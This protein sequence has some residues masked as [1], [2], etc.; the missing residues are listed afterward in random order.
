MDMYKLQLVTST[1]SQ[2]GPE[3]HPVFQTIVDA[4]PFISYSGTQVH[5]FVELCLELGFLCCM[6]LRLY[7]HFVSVF[8]DIIQNTC[9]R[10]VIG[11][12]YQMDP[13]NTR[14][15]NK[16]VMGGNSVICYYL[17]GLQAIE[18]DMTF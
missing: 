1:I 18:R 11:A 12:M 16:C 4:L 3:P 17:K 5:I 6:A 13:R 14:L 7:I 15:S 2:V 8:G 10:H 9:K